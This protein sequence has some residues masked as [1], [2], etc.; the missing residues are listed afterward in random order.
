MDTYP[1]P[2]SFTT[3]VEGVERNY[4]SSSKFIA[5][6]EDPLFAASAQ[7]LHRVKF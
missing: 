2:S 6:V 5:D 7:F 4:L 3:Q 1:Q